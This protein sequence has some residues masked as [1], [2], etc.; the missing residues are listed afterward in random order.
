MKRRQA[1]NLGTVLLAAGVPLIFLSWVFRS[2]VLWV[3]AA[4]CFAGGFYLLFAKV[5][6]KPRRRRRK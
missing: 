5:L 4:G 1:L 2:T 3:I 6:A